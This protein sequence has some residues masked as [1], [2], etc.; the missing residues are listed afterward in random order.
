MDQLQEFK[1]LLEDKIH[2]STA[3]R[4]MVNTEGWGILLNTFNDMKENQLAELSSQIPGNE[5]GILAAHAVW[6][7]VVHTLDQI[8][9]AVT[10]A[11]NEGDAARQ[12]LDLLNQNP[13]ED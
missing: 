5:K 12:E 6:Y 7:S 10:S 2:K 1:E 4:L 13:Q 8:V 9:S 3:L 11:I